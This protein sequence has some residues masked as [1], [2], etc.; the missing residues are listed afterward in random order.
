MLWASWRAEQQATLASCFTCKTT[1]SPF[2]QKV[3]SPWLVCRDTCIQKW[4]VWPYL[5]AY[6]WQEGREENEWEMNA[7]AQMEG[8]RRNIS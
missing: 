6:A 2:S 3:L 7:S 8:I 1:T 4:A 5:A